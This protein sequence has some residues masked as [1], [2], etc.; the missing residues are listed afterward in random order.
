VIRRVLTYPHPILKRP[1]EPVGLA[2]A[3]R[4]AEDLADTMASSPGCVGLAAPQVG[5][6]VRVAVVDVRRHPLGSSSN[7]LLVLV[8][9]AV[10]EQVGAE[11]GREGCLSLPDLTADVRRAR[12][13][14]VAGEALPGGRAWCQGFEAR[15]VQHELDHLD[16]VLIL[17]RVAS[18]H[19]LH[20][21]PP[22][23]GRRAAG[24]AEHEEPGELAS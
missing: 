21:R 20:P 10:L 6:P 4:L 3:M 14:L 15:A 7:G 23:R 2:F 1:C 24:P 11:I 5:E 22:S 16:G 17:D 12:R 18:V 9:A 13:L 8:N 19:A